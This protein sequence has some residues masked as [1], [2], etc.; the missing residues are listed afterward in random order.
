MAQGCVMKTRTA[1]PSARVSTMHVFTLARDLYGPGA[2]NF[3]DLAG[4]Q[5]HADKERAVLALSEPLA[6]R[7][8]LHL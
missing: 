6:P 1:E 7:Q 2:L 4:N 8:L 5:A 3:S